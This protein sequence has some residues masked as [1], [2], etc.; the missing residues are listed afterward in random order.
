MAAVGSALILMAKAPVPGSVKTRLSPPLGPR[1]AAALYACI[2]EDVAGEM[3]GRVEGMRRYLFHAPA[4]R[5]PYFRSAPFREF[6]LRPQRGTDL[7]ARMDR[8][9]RAV[10]AEGATR[11]VVIGAD[12][13]ALS[14]G[15]VRAAFGELSGSADVVLGPCADGG[16]YLIGMSSPHGALFRGIR[17]GGPTVLDDVCRRCRATGLR[18]AFLPSEFDVDTSADLERLRRWAKRHAAPP[19]PRTRRWISGR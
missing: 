13:P 3:S 6:R 12:C 1:A 8:A 10:F 15:R 2:L 18:F 17:W 5:A 11:A 9:L 16:F 7:G 4:Q 19:C 14:L